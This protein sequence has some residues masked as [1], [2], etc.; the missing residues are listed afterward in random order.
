[1]STIIEVQA[2]LHGLLSEGPQVGIWPLASLEA[3]QARL[4]PFWV[5]PFRTR[6][7]GRISSPELARDLA[8]DRNAPAS[9]LVPGYEFCVYS[10]STWHIHQLP[11]VGG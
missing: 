7:I 1:M 6:L 3:R 10:A 11:S 5:K 8:S 4:A 9:H 2:R